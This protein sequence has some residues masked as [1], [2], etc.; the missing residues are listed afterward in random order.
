MNKVINKIST[1]TVSILLLIG[2]SGCESRGDIKIP[3]E[4]I[5]IESQSNKKMATV[6]FYRSNDHLGLM[7][8]SPITIRVDSPSMAFVS[9]DTDTNFILRA[10]RS[11]Y[12]S[13]T[14]TPGV[15]TFS[16][17]D[18]MSQVANLKAS[19]TYYLAQTFHLGGI[20]GIQFRTKQD[21]LE[22]VENAKQIEYTG[23]KCNSWSGCTT[24]LVN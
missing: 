22:S 18:I 14:Y 6:V 3:L 19:K 16:V 21:F 11:E 17:G 13:N 10:S 7:Q 4:P 23:E 9:E 12:M 1:L 24:R 15:H 2:I 5:G 8:F 20:T